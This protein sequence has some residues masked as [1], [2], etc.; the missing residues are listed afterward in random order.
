MHRRACRNRHVRIGVRACERACV[1]QMRRPGDSTMLCS[2]SYCL[3]R[4]HR[5]K[6][7]AAGVDSELVSVPS[8][9]AA[10]AT[11]LASGCCQVLSTQSASA[12]VPIAEP[13]RDSRQDVDVPSPRPSRRKRKWE[14]RQLATFERATCV[15]A[16][17]DLKPV[18]ARSQRAEPRHHS[19]Y[20]LFRLVRFSRVEAL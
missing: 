1:F 5:R 12:Q 16:A 9:P 3:S 19:V 6:A 14:Q 2:N 13:Q 10:R 7:A 8:S 18:S 4:K 17:A 15:A 11:R 20:E